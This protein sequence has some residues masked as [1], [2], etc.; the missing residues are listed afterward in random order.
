[1]PNHVHLIA[2]PHEEDSLSG[3]IGEAHRRY[4]TLIHSREGWRG[5]LW[6]GRFA[7]FPMDEAHLY[8]A[9]RYIELNPVRASLVK[10]PWQYRWSSAAAHM[11]GRDDR[12]VRVKPLLELFGN[13]ENYLSIGITPEQTENL[14]KHE[15]SGIPLGSKSFLSEIEEKYGREFRSRKRGPK[16]PWKQK[17][18]D[19][20]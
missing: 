6:Q 1:M 16:G 18:D 17:N 10:K 7:S 15:R 19:S 5:Y 20:E 2:V 11:D 3:A 12:L 13:W 8:L 14:R 9:A 4:T